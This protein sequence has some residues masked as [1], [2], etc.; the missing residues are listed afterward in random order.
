MKLCLACYHLN[1]GDPQVCGY[2]GRSWG[3][4]V[5]Q[6]GHTSAPDATFCS[7]CSSTEL[8]E[9]GPALPI[10]L[11]I[12]FWP[13]VGLVAFYMA[14]HYLPHLLKSSFG[15]AACVMMFLVPLFCLSLIL[16]AGLRKWL[17]WLFL[18]VLNMLWSI[19]ARILGIGLHKK[20]LKNYQ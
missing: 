20:K 9:A 14:K 2:C 12:I 4:R 16:P 6:R 5:C 18:G 13:F 1:T 3:L 7:V 8:T 15:L 10:W 11:R 19:V 17:Y